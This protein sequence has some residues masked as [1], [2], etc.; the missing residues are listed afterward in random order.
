[1]ATKPPRIRKGLADVTSA[2]NCVSPA[3][4][5]GGQ[6]KK[7]AAP[8]P[9][10]SSL[11]VVD[12][13]EELKEQQLPTNGRKAELIARVR[14][15]RQNHCAAP[16]ARLRRR[17][18]AAPAASP[19]QQP[20]RTYTSELLAV[21]D[22]FKRS[23]KMA[24]TPPGTSGAS[25]PEGEPVAEPSTPGPTA[26]TTAEPQPTPSPIVTE[27]QSIYTDSIAAEVAA[28][29]EPEPVSR[30]ACSAVARALSIVVGLAAIVGGAAL[31]AGLPTGGLASM[32][33]QAQ[34]AVAE[35]SEFDAAAA[36]EQAQLTVA[37][38]N[39][40]AA[41][42]HV[43]Q[44]FSE[45]DARATCGATVDAVAAAADSASAYA[46]DT[47]APHVEQLSATATHG[48][49]AT[50]VVLSEHYNAASV[51]VGEQWQTLSSAIELQTSA[52]SRVAEL[53]AQVAALEAELQSGRR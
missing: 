25:I 2:F 19:D 28:E 45:F 43:E 33:E 15:A 51:A 4:G 12:L 24:R 21:E 49:T 53:E 17:S 38:L 13:R 32:S 6:Q 30:S 50:A 20:A 9:S 31:V 22:P 39:A 47:L 41:L 48:I 11:R 23:D 14:E 42:E 7:P 29:P 1:M 18:A 26:G 36:L 10:P 37:E 16:A 8:D 27:Q 5:R 3:A 35:L 46:T 34:L 40:T 44:A 52:G